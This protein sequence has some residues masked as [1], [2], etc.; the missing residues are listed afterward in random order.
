MAVVGPKPVEMVALL[1]R[2]PQ[3]RG[4]VGRVV[5]HPSADTVIVMTWSRRRTEERLE[6]RLDHCV[7]VEV[8]GCMLSTRAFT[9][10][11]A[12]ELMPMLYQVFQD[13]TVMVCG[14]DDA[15][16]PLPP[17]RRAA[18]DRLVAT[19]L[20]T[21]TWPLRVVVSRASRLVVGVVTG[22]ELGGL[23]CGLAFEPL[24]QFAVVASF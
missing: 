20:R 1:V 23:R 9:V 16:F 10:H 7:P 22:G 4:M 15:D 17:A 24:D 13:D 3:Y 12:V 5:G 18:V 14:A 21:I 11:P 8:S 19:K 2:N 6:L